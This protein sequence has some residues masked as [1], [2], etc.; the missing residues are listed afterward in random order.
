MESGR[1]HVISLLVPFSSALVF[2]KTAPLS[3]QAVRMHSLS[4]E[5]S[6]SDSSVD[7]MPTSGGEEDDDH[8]G[9]WPEQ[10]GF[11]VGV[12]PGSV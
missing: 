11:Q 7:S 8:D 3:F 6:G 9:D 10:T 5:W 4:V 1:R 12:W 2:G